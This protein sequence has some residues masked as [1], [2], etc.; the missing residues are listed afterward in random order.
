MPHHDHHRIEVRINRTNGVAESYEFMTPPLDIPGNDQKPIHVTIVDSQPGTRVEFSNRGRIVPTAAGSTPSAQ[1]G[2]A[3]GGRKQLTIP[4]HN[5]R[6]ST[7]PPESFMLTIALD[8][9]G[10][11]IPPADHCHPS[12][13]I[14]IRAHEAVIRNDGIP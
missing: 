8:E 2:F 12:G 4:W 14:S 9:G 6:P 5:R 7:S 3:A 1:P 13:T 11:N 10:T